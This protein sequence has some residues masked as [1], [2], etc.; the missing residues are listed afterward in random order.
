ME[1][2]KS[3]LWLVFLC[4]I[5]L[6]LICSCSSIEY[7]NCFKNGEKVYASPIEPIDQSKYDY[8]NSWRLN[9]GDE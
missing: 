2:N 8:C 7:W 4:F 1:I 6:V 5:I 9:A 3:P